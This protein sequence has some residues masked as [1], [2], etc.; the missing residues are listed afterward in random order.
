MRPKVCKSICIHIADVES[1]FCC[2]AAYA[3][4]CPQ[5]PAC[6]KLRGTTI[7]S[8]VVGVL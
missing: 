4:K 3:L 5:Q 7:G 2:D 8:T 6:A 1:T